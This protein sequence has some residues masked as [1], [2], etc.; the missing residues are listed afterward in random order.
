VTTAR[1]RRPR[2]ADPLAARRCALRTLVTAEE[3][4]LRFE[5][6]FDRQLAG[7]SIS[8]K[9]RSLAHQ[10]A[11]GTMKLQRRFDYMIEQLVERRH[12]PLPRVIQQILRMGLYQLTAL[13]RVPRHAAV[14]TSVDLAKQWGHAG[15]ARLVNA[16]LRKVADERIEFEWPKRKDDPARYLA[17]W[18]SYPDWMVERWV[19][20]AGEEDAERFCEIGNGPGGLTI[21]LVAGRRTV[22]ETRKQL[23][24]QGVESEPGRWFSHYLFLPDPPPVR[25][26]R[27]VGAGDATVQNEAAAAAV[28]LLDVQPGETVV[29][30][31]AAPGGKS[32]LI[33]EL[34]GESG[35]VAAIDLNA[36]RM[37]RV[38]QNM[39]RMNLHQVKPI[40]A[41]G[42]QL[43][44]RGVRK[45]LVDT[46]CSGLGLLH[47]H[48]DLRWQKQ[49][50]DIER[51]ADLQFELLSA[52]LEAVEPG[53]RV[54]YSTC[55][56]TREENEGVIARVLEARR[57]VSVID[58]RPLLPKGV[59]CDAHWVS[60]APD[61]PQ[62]DGAFAC[63]L[64]KSA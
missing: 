24:G 14:S 49:T 26:L 8:H 6:A 41:N 57:D 61:P 52:A 36:R 33:A 37:R 50:A 4:E 16:V 17:L 63:A 35:R 21:R 38:V 10:I 13:D 7:Q 47:R 20:E 30:I 43:P 29:E 5:T 55:T 40:V 54:V 45:I 3:H 51:L 9:D 64:E 19:R 34:A 56:T 53:G 18:H 60:I 27:Q 39:E 46:P 59:P 32:S 44:V 12:R 28:M 15:T 22:A 58:P 62:I 2:R 1:K 25:E 42:L 11:A 23:R 48:P 31:G